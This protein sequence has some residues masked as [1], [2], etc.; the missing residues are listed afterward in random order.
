MDY[1]VKTNIVRK[2][3][4]TMEYVI[5]I[6]D[7]VNVMNFGKAMIV[8]KKSAQRIVLN[9]DFAKMVNVNALKDGLVKVVTSKNVI[10]TVLIM[11]SA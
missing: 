11:V 5:L 6:L 7:Y 1:H 3:V 9:M 10:L 4:M 2:I 8:V